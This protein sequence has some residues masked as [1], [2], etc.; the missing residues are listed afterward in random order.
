MRRLRKIAKITGILLAS[1]YLLATIGL[2]LYQDKLLYFPYP[3]T[4]QRMSEISELN[5]DIEPVTIKAA[6]G[7]PLKGWIV[8][9]NRDNAIYYFGGNG[10]EVS[11]MIDQAKEM[12]DYAFVLINYRGYGESQGEASQKSLFSDSEE[13]YRQIQEEYHYSKVIIMGR[14][15][16]SGVALHLADCIQPDGLILVTPYDRMANIAKGQIP[17]IF[18]VSLLL[19]DKYESDKIAKEIKTPTIILMAENDTIVPNENT[20]ALAKEF[21]DPVPIITIPGAGHNSISATAEY[22]ESIRNFLL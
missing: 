22:W 9:K 11:Y 8:N 3:L 5:A 21:P 13:I 1:L 6:D 12:K 20:L 17:P 15:L 4:T 10:E 2:F 14:S 7:T 16:G 19:Q 18:P